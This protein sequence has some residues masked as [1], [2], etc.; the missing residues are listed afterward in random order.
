M[1]VCL[2]T[3]LLSPHF[4]GGYNLENL[5]RR[6]SGLR[7]HQHRR[8]VRDHH[9]RIDLSIGSV[10]ALT[11]CLLPWLVVSG[12]WPGAA[13]GGGRRA[14]RVPRP[15]SR[16]ARFTKV[17]VQPFVVT[18][19]GLLI[20]RGPPVAS[21]ATVQGFRSGRGCARWPSGRSSA[22]RGDVRD[23]GAR[24]HPA[25][26]RGRGRR[27]LNLS[28]PGGTCCWKRNEQARFSGVRTQRLIVLAYVIVAATLAG[29]YGVPFVLDDGS[30]QPSLMGN[31]YELWAIAAAARRCSRAAAKARSSA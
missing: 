8:S 12:G 23:P 31:F 3:A 28:V 29:L 15:V 10:I 11:G 24:R 17:G 27:L 9:G 22:G 2:I 26:R 18:L 5:L 25:R 21:P 16:P 19:C 13:A 20:Y 4:Y 6:T 30:A 14:G 1:T 7:H